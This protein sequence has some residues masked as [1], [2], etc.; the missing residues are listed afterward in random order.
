MG[1]QQRM[2]KIVA[3][4]VL[5]YD[6]ERF[7]IYTDKEPSEEF[8]DAIAYGGP[9]AADCGFC[10]RFHAAEE[11]Q[12]LRDD[13]IHIFWHG[14]SSLTTGYLDNRSFVFDCPCNAATMYEMF[15]WQHLP[16]TAKYSVARARKQLEAAQDKLALAESIVIPKQD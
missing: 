8:L 14:T 12:G 15:L 3:L 2:S 11:Y 16:V 13:N 9:D 7:P 1:Q 5:R 10:G 6:S 4:E